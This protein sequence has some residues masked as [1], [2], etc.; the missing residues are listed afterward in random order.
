MGLVVVDLVPNVGHCL[1]GFQRLGDHINTPVCYMPVY[2]DM[3][4]KEWSDAFWSSEFI[5]LFQAG[6]LSVPGCERLGS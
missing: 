5:S 3:S 1:E 2:S 4:H 6:Q